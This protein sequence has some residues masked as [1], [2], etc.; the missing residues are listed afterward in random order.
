VN[1]DMLQ[2]RKIVQRGLD[3]DI[4]SGDITTRLIVPSSVNATGAI[5]AEEEGV[6]AGLPVAEMCFKLVDSSVW[7][8]AQVRDGDRV[9]PGQKLADI[10]GPAD[11]LLIAERTALNFLQR[12]SGIA[13]KTSDFAGMTDGTSAK[14]VDTR[15][16]TP[17]LRL[18][19]KYAV[20][21]GGGYNHRFGLD[22][23]ILIKDNHIAVAGGVAA[24]VR[25]AKANSP[26][27][28]KIEVEVTSLA[29]IE[30]ALAA[31]ADILLLDN[32]PL[33]ETVQAV[34]F[35]GGRALIEASGGVNMDTVEAIAR[36]GVDF[37]SV[38]MLTH[39]VE[40]LDISLDIIP[41]DAPLPGTEE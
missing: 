41:S 20:R 40:S 6:V 21:A 29:E 33:E 31:G 19:E 37:I 32:M 34:Q 36:A 24:A 39:S 7:F 12:L 2:V 18:L 14:I 11:S 10:A 35:I 28:L 15:K 22:D 8:I 27:T 3:E 25:A 1:L 9:S 17:G 38:G 5:V 13:T 23:G 30:E 4:G 16:T 26:H